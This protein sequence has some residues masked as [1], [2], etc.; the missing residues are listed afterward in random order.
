MASSV[1]PSAEEQ[2][3]LDAQ[4]EE[5]QRRELGRRERV[6]VADVLHQS[7]SWSQSLEEAEARWLYEQNQ[8]CAQQEVCEAPMDMDE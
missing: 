2:A 7:T 1:T 5:Q 6:W 3:W 8:R 4:L